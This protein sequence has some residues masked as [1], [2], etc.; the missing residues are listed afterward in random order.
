MIEWIGIGFLIGVGVW[1]APIVI[2]IG[3]AFVVFLAAVA[4]ILY[5]RVMK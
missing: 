5:L 3:I 1:L 2:A 4:R